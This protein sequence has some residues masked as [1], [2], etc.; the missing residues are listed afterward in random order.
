MDLC[1]CHP[2]SIDTEKFIKYLVELRKA[3]KDKKI[4]IFF[5]N[6]GVHRSYVVRNKLS[7]LDI[8]CIFN[9]AYA[10]EFNPIE[11]VFAKIK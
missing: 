2:K 8:P 7:E 6:L 3:H 5:D 1:V 10:P 11:L 4:A 9:A